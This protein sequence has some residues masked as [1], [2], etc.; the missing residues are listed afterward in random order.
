MT[1]GKRR[2]NSMPDE[3]SVEV[4][5]DDCLVRIILP[6]T[7]LRIFSRQKRW[8]LTG[9]NGLMKV[10]VKNIDIRQGCCIL[11]VT[12]SGK[13]FINFICALK[14]FSNF[15]FLIE[16]DCLVEV[17]FGSLQ[18]FNLAQFFLREDKKSSIASPIVNE[19]LNLLSCQPRE[20]S[21]QCESN[22]RLLDLVDV[23]VSDSKLNI[24]ASHALFR[25]NQ[26]VERDESKE[27]NKQL[28]Q[29]AKNADLLLC[30]VRVRAFRSSSPTHSVHF[31]FLLFRSSE[32]S[33]LLPVVHFKLHESLLLN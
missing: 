6:R 32:L 33:L 3:R 26:V 7:S 20:M 29:C 13:G 19:W 15:T 22:S 5:A 1:M 8:I 24:P 21:V 10:P 23:S 30:L 17:Q 2:S 18:P 9:I 16:F 4:S 14:D 31:V 12:V 27:R 28:H 11:T 25:L